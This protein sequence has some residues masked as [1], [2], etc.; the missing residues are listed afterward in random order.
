LDGVLGCEKVHFWS[1]VGGTVVGSMHIC[2]TPFG[3]EGGV[4]F[5]VWIWNW[6]VFSFGL[7]FSFVI[8]FFKWIPY[9]IDSEERCLNLGVCRGEQ[10]DDSNQ[11]GESNRLL[12]RNEECC[13]ICSLTALMNEFLAILIENL[14]PD[15]KNDFL[16]LTSVKLISSCYDIIEVIKTRFESR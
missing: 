12:K 4:W 6:F 1:Q 11:Q 7:G 16:W 13:W 14:F 3:N 9:S 15:E 8:W 5:R 10:C 2:I